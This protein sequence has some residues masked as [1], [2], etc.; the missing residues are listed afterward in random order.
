[1]CISAAP[2]LPAAPAPPGCVAGSADTLAPIRL[3]SGPTNDDVASS[4]D[5]LVARAQAGEGTALE[6]LLRRHYDRIYA[7]CRRLTANDADAAD[8]AQNATIAVARGLPRF[9]VRSQFSTWAYRIAVNCSID[10]M[11]RRSRWPLASLEDAP[12]LVS[13]RGDDTEVTAARLDVDTALRQ[14]PAQ[15]RAA[16]VLRD[17][18]GLD[19]AEIA[20]ML[21]LPPGTVRSRIARGRGALVRLLDPSRSES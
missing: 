13:S 6:T 17:M 3:R 15:F 1:V 8:A 19:Y 12:P 4:D 7:V 5:A 9:D 21:D 11:R 14:L 10:E 2:A 18:C 16:V 20:D